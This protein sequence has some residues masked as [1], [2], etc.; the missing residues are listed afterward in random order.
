MGDIAVRARSTD[1]RAS[2]AAS[3]AG[4]SGNPRV[5]RQFRWACLE[6]D[7]M[8]T[9]PI[10]AMLFAGFLLIFTACASTTLDMTWRDPT[11]EGRPFTKVLVVGS[12]DSPDSRRIF[13]DTVVGELKTQGVEAVASYTLIP[14][15]GEV[16]RDQVMEAVKTSGADS[17]L[18]T[19]LVGIETKTAQVP[20]SSPGA[21]AMDLYRYYSPMEAQT[22]VQQDYQVANLESNLFDARTGK[23]VWWGR[24]QTF[25]TTNIGQ[26]SRELG[27]KV[28]K[29]LKSAKLL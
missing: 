3:F 24:S 14:D 7:S 20:V 1:S 11:Y 16:K 6:E 19:R 23:M 26:V 29:A 21:G 13:E 2:R 5:P 15:A 8:K 12:T 4:S 10:A 9:R 25:P 18:S 28:I 17:V 27:E 22:T